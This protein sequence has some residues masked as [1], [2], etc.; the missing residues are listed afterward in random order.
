[1]RR[2]SRLKI[3][4]AVPVALVIVSV[5]AF[6]LP[7]Y[8]PLLVGMTVF[9]MG[10]RELAAVR[11][12]ARERAVDD[13]PVPPTVDFSGYAYDERRLTWIVWQN[14]RPVGSCSA[15]DAIR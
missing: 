15:D 11:A 1:M 6:P 13:L 7:L 5:V 9:V 8:V 2:R 12:A 10:R 4:L 3:G 14:G